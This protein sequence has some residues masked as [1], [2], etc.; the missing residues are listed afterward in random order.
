MSF[1]YFLEGIRCGFFDIFFSVVTLFGE[2]TLFMAF[3]MI[4]FWCVDKYKGYYILCVGFLGTVINQFLKMLFRIPRPW[5]LDPNFTIVESAREAATGYSFPSGHTQTAV[6]LY[7]GIAR[8]SKKRYVILPAVAL[9]VLIPLS[10]MYLGVH[11][12]ADVLVSTAIALA[13]VFGAYPFFMKAKEK[14]FIMY[15]LISAL[16]VLVVAFLL[17]VCFYEFPSSCY[18]EENIHNIESAR[19]NGFTLLGCLLGLIVTYTVDTL[20]IKFDTKAVFW[21]QI[22]KV[23]VGILL[24]LAVKELLRAPIDTIFNGSLVGRSVRYFLM[25]IVGGLLWPMSFKWLS[26]LG[27]NKSEDIK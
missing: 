8:I 4:I 13:L 2:E 15:V 19:K 14:P 3:G 25:V 18:L 1:L 26:K 10:R 23:A 9:C 24:V 20:Y 22:I 12:P 6:G 21:V 11:T 17:F 7:G 5:V 27:K 16:M